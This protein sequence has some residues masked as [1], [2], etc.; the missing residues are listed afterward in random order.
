MKKFKS[1]PLVFSVVGVLSL[2]T[3]SVFAQEN[4]NS[5]FDNISIN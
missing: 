4:I 5:N 3:T 1:L 2:S